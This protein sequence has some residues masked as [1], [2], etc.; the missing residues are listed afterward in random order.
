MANW[1]HDIQSGT[2]FGSACARDCS[3]IVRYIA[4]TIHREQLSGEICVAGDPCNS[5]DLPEVGQLMISPL[6][7]SSSEGN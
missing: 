2:I 5:F 4:P 1:S 6:L 3:A 7:H